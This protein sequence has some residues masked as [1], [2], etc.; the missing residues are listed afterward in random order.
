[1]A[2]LMLILTSF[3]RF[4]V[5]H[6]L[7]VI[8][9]KL[10]PLILV[11][12]SENIGF[13]SVLFRFGTLYQP[14]V[15]KHPQ[16]KISKLCFGLISLVSEFTNFLQLFHYSS[17]LSISYRL[18]FFLLGFP[19]Q[20]ILPFLSSSTRYF[21]V[22]ASLKLFSSL[23]HHCMLLALLIVN[24]AHIVT[25]ARQPM[26]EIFGSPL[27]PSNKSNQIKSIDFSEKVDLSYEHFELG[28]N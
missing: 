6:V 5:I 9:T 18:S 2:S 20:S 22:L 1:M 7:A 12:R 28:T 17:L 10:E 4:Q 15:L 3:F 23:L 8:P 11:L 25:R 13:P 19:L 27:S 14:P 24:L 16:L 26:C 21:P